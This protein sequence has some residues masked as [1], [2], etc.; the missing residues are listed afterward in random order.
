MV[1]K[2]A[3]VSFVERSRYKVA[4]PVI[5]L[6]ISVGEKV[7]GERWTILDRNVLQNTLEVVV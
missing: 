6:L 7:A 4:A 5:G 3:I 1:L 2:N